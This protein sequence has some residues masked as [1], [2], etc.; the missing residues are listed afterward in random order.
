MG[1]FAREY[2]NWQKFV[3][4]YVN[5][6]STG[7]GLNKRSVPGWKPVATAWLFFWSVLVEFYGRFELSCMLNTLI[8]MNKDCWWIM[9]G[10]GCCIWCFVNILMDWDVKLDF[11]DKVDISHNKKRWVW[12]ENLY[13]PLQGN[14][15]LS[16]GNLAMFCL[17]IMLESTKTKFVLNWN[18]LVFDWIILDQKI[19]CQNPDYDWITLLPVHDNDF[20]R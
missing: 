12:P 17:E 16:C 3:R 19:D 20:N 2:V 4:E 9:A 5:W 8:V 15:L 1:F 7:G 18:W 6:G 13:Q 10:V 14:L 11:L